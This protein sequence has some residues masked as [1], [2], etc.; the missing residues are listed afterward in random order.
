GGVTGF[1]ANAFQFNTSQ[2]QNSTGI[3]SFFVSQSG[4]NLSLNFIPIPEPS[5][6]ALLALGLGA[7]WIVSRR[8]K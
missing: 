1:S 5:T 7:V 8:R 4:N 6:Y 3:G 2:F